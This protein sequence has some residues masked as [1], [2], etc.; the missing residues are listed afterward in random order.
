MAQFKDYSNT[1]TGSQAR[2]Q[3]TRPFPDNRNYWIIGLSPQGADLNENS[4]DVTC[5]AIGAGHE[6]PLPQTDIGPTSS[7]GSRQRRGV[8]GGG[9]REPLR[10]MEKIRVSGQMERIRIAGL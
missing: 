6:V 9:G 2:P 1:V 7:S 3:K 5:M 4:S 8:R 10:V